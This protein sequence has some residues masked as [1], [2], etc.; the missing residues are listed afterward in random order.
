MGV[1]RILRDP[2]TIWA[3]EGDPEGHHAYRHGLVVNPRDHS[4][5]RR[6]EARI[7]VVVL[8]VQSTP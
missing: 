1:L 5:R 7:R 6:G 3:L 8:P 2:G 4:H